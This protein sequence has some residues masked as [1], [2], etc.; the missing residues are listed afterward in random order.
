MVPSS[1]SHKI[2]ASGNSGLLH[3]P[4][5]LPQ[6]VSPFLPICF[7]GKRGLQGHLQEVSVL[8]ALGEVFLTT[9]MCLELYSQVT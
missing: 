6:V 7:L 3:I 4:R 2:C 5:T 9:L 1:A 8:L